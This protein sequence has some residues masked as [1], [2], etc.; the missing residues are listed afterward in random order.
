MERRSGTAVTFH[1]TIKNRLPLDNA[2]TDVIARFMAT[3][4]KT[5]TGSTIVGPVTDPNN[6]TRGPAVRALRLALVARTLSVDDG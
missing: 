1:S 5:L 6:M 4:T 2:G 3:A